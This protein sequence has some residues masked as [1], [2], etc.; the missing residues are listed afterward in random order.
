[1]YAYHAAPWSSPSASLDTLWNS[2]DC[3]EAQTHA[4][5]H[6]THVHKDFVLEK[7]GNIEGLRHTI[8]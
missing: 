3:E 2:G 5:E 1:M 7:F 4:Y 8:N 6:Y